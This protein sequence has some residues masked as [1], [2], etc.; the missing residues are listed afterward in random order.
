GTGANACGDR[1]PAEPSFFHGTFVS[2]LIAANSDNGVGIAGLDWNA[3]IL[4]VR[5]LGKC[6]GT[7]DDILDG[8]LWAAGVPVAGVPP[9]PNPA[10][11][12]N[13]SLYGLSSCPLAFQYAVHIA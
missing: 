12:I 8:I 2:G 4:P 9:N 13:M 3:R 6:G 1:A 10:R 5:T 11:D 7:F